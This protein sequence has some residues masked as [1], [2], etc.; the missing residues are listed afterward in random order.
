MSEWVLYSS[1]F[2]NV[3]SGKVRASAMIFS[4]LAICIFSAGPVSAE[5]SPSNAELYQ[6]ILEMK[7]SQE[8]LQQEADQARAEATE[9]K[10]ELA[11][12]QEVLK[13][14]QE[15]LRVTEGKVLE[16]QE[17]VAQTQEG[18]AETQAEMGTAPSSS[19]V[20]ILE[21]EQGGYANLGFMYKRP[22]NDRYTY[23]VIDADTG[24][25]NQLTAV[26][27][28]T[29]YEPG[30]NIG[31]GYLFSS[32]REAFIN[33]AYLDLDEKDDVVDPIGDADLKCT[34]CPVDTL[35][36]DRDENIDSAQAFY[37]IDYRVLDVG[38]A[39]N[40]S[41]GNSLDVRL[42]GG[43][44]YASIDEEFGGKYN[45]I[46]DDSETETVNVL[47][48]NEF[49]GIGPT[50]SLDLAYNVRNT[51]FSLLGN[52]GVSLLVG[53]N[54]FLYD[55]RDDDDDIV[56][57]DSEDETR[58]IPVLSAGLGAAY[59]GNTGN[60][61]YELKVGYEFES[62]IDLFSRVDFIDDSDQPAHTRE[63]TNFDLHGLFLRGE[64]RW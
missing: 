22:E 19:V 35:D 49:W 55:A 40:L 36:I 46:S 54:D 52:F 47:I 38:V 21:S 26:G 27:I 10:R 15:S 30:F 20:R 63:D 9:A 60:V 23:A 1:S 11:R 58:I 59:A 37:E 3:T 43:L 50:A 61:E 16:T 39:Q 32:G 7:A 24:S 45:S 51:G 8:Q 28:D 17:V 44:R 6:M 2:R 12:T 13:S 14:T 64:V 34:L 41:V 31:A 29:E 25:D 42:G 62:W 18:L 53:D 56:S 48:Q 57:L 5:D 33:F 4:L